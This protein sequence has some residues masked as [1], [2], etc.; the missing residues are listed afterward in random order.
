[1]RRWPS[2]WDAAVPTSVPNCSNHAMEVLSPGKYVR[3][4][5]PADMIEEI[6]EVRAQAPD[7]GSIYLEVETI[8]ASIWNALDL[9]EALA[10][11][12]SRRPKKL[13]FR[14]NLAI[15]SSFVKKEEKVR[16][17]FEY[18]RKA[19]VVCLNVGLET[20]SERIRTLM[21]RPHYSNAEIIGFSTLAKEYGIATSLYVLIGLPDE[22]PKDFMETVNVVRQI[23]PDA[24]LLAIFYP[25]I[26][27][28]LYETTKE[29]G[30]IPA[31][32]LEPGGERRRATLDLPDFPR[33]RVRFEYV[34]FW[35]RAYKGVWPLPKIFF[36]M[37]RAYITPYPRIESAY[38][39][40][41]SHIPVL[42]SFK[43]IYTPGGVLKA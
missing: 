40:L 26:G 35:Y 18:C 16:E 15:H 17:F 14:M 39:Y 21:R 3:Y 31:T 2:W 4:R 1:M 22:T 8:G 38:R 34:I 23:N 12:N 30:L 7:V 25:Y 27:T 43:R 32:G 5:S 36:R 24:I 19:N 42:W 20:G 29:R 28:D 9:F 6:E 37:A 33:W 11:Y 10:E 13:E 41:R